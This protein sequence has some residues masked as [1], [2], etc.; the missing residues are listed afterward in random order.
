MI[1]HLLGKLEENNF[2]ASIS[3]LIFECVVYEKI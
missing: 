2:N 1:A 3:T